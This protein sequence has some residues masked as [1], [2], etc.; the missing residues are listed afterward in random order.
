[1]DSLIKQQEIGSEVDEMR[2]LKALSRGTGSEFNPGKT[3]GYK[4][5]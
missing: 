5:G 4:T 1:L 2:L 3:V